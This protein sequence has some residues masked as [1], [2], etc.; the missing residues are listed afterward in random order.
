MKNL[1]KYAA[2]QWRSMLA[3]IVILFVQAYCDLSLPAYT[4]DIVNVGIQQGGIEDQIPET[5]SVEEMER[6][7]LFVPQDSQQ[8]VLDAYETD[9]S[10]Y[11]TEAYVLKAS[12]AEDEDAMADLEEI[13][14][15]PM[16]LTAGFESGSDMT[17]QIEDQINANLPAQMAGADADIFD[18]MAM[19]P[20]QQREAMAESMGEQLDEIPDSIL[21]QAAVSYVRS[22]YENV[23][24]DVDKM[25]TDYLLSTG[26]KMA[27]LA[28]L[29][30]AASVMVG[31]L[32]S[33]V[34]ASTE[35]CKI[36]RVWKSERLPEKDYKH[37]ARQ[38][39]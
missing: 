33:R 21:D 7:L 2:T 22:A 27:A 1:F 5:I 13:L 15:G 20:E 9:S 14:Q 39:L 6:L 18:I 10:T 38:R 19:L 32:A 29:G 34:G 26:G 12:V 28:F 25:Q 17:K 4:S 37:V 30:M 11:E 31:F 35:P 36:W 8:K 3:I 24:M 16:M 23:G